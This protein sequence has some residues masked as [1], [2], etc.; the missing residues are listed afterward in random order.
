MKFIMIIMISK[1]LKINLCNDNY[2]YDYH[3]S[4]DFDVRMCETA[5][6]KSKSNHLLISSESICRLILET[7]MIFQFINLQLVI[8]M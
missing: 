8:L 7:L 4:N 5:K 1:I 2:D 6:P 3:N